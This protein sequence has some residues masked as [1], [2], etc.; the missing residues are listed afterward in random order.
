M[1]RKQRTRRKLRKAGRS[2]PIP[3]RPV[4]AIK[5]TK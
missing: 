1:T 4:T 2:G 3:P 5:V